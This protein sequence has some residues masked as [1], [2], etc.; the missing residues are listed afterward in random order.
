MQH[1][2]S[3]S[4]CQEYH[5][6]LVVVVVLSLLLIFQF[7][8]SFSP[9]ET[10]RL[11]DG[12]LAAQL[13]ESSQFPGAFTGIWQDLG[14]VGAHGGSATLDITFFLRWILGPVGFCKFHAPLSILILGVCA[15]T[16]FRTLGFGSGVCIAGAIAAALNSNFFSNACWGLASRPL[17]LALMFLAVA[18]WVTPRIQSRWFRVAFSGFAIGMGVTESADVGVIFSLIFAAFVV[19]RELISSDCSGWRRRLTRGVIATLAVALVAGL[20]A[21]HLLTALLDAGINPVKTAGTRFET[22]QQHWDWAT[23][24]SL[25][26]AE[27]PRIFVAGLHGY[28]MNTGDGSDYWGS[29]GRSP[30]W[31]PGEPGARYSGAGEYAGVVV[32]LIALF[33]LMGSSTNPRQR[34]MIWFWC[35]FALVSLAFALGRYAPFYKYLVEL[36]YFS[37]TRNPIKW[38]HGFHFSLLMLFAY[39]LESLTQACSR[40]ASVSLQSVSEGKDQWTKGVAI[41]RRWNRF[42]ALLLILTAFIGVCYS[43]AR[44]ALQHFLEQ[45]GW[46]IQI[47]PKL[48]ATSI[49]EVWISILLLSFGIALIW[50]FVSLRF[51]GLRSRI[52]WAALLVLLVFDLSRANAPWIAYYN[53]EQRHGSTA[54]WEQLAQGPLRQRVT[55]APLRH[56]ELGLL[57]WLQ[58][59]YQAEWMQHQFQAFNIP[60]FDL[61]QNPRPAPDE[62]TYKAN[63]AGNIGRLW[64]LTSTR[65]VL[66]LAAPFAD[67]MNQLVDPKHKRFHIVTNFTV[68]QNP[69]TGFPPRL[70]AEGPF[71]LLEFS[72]AMPRASLFGRWIEAGDDSTLGMLANPEFQ[73]T[74]LVLVAKS[75][76]APQASPEQLA[77]RSNL[78]VKSYS[79]KRI[80]MESEA[81]GP[82]VLLLNDR[83]HPD[84]RVF[85]DGVAAPLLRCNYL[86]RGV[87]VPAGQHGIE[88]RFEPSRRGLQVGAIM[89]TV[90]SFLLFYQ[91]VYLRRGVCTR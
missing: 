28:L 70:Q 67:V 3:G 31:K 35:S 24:W 18:A 69:V 30:G 75:T 46:G 12:P 26:K 37:S 55:V 54:L 22:S 58:S 66:G 47:I 7:H 20:S 65:Y 87:H 19:M 49:R 32:C 45:E 68:E 62:Q 33:G 15:W 27:I 42:A 36:P 89:V 50:G 5:G 2:G 44:P 1:K 73:P 21:I 14:G 86:M 39:G 76:P 29:A 59:V 80:Q 61:I 64:E 88:F 48:T 77:T 6:L 84:W 63:L 9:G 82:T 81:D 60:S 34:P 74:N 90:I 17:T 57:E 10:L 53:Y 56:P 78:V 51:T 4:R 8:R 43:L 40:S 41:A 11:N 25:P 72:G 85:V 52:G 71:G 13:S 38:M 83:Y 91:F 16:G 23:Q 79:P